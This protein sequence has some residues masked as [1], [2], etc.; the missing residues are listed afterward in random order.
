MLYG[1]V[2]ICLLYSTAPGSG[3]SAP[4]LDDAYETRRLQLDFNL[5]EI[6]ATVVNYACFVRGYWAG[7]AGLR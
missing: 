5:Q 6:T 1:T 2:D 4:Y 7:V 3:L